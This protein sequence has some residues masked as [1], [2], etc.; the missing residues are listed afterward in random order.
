M[1]GMTADL[2]ENRI[3]FDQNRGTAT[4]RQN[5]TCPEGNRAF[6][7]FH[8]MNEMNERVFPKP[9]KRQND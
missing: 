5:F 3:C 9:A 8:P 1:S 4:L 6:Y 2:L 7:E